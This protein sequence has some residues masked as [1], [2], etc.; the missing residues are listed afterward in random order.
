MA[1]LDPK[2]PRRRWS[3]LWATARG[4]VVGLL[5]A[6]SAHPGMLVVPN[7]SFEL[8]A[9][10][11]VNVDIAEWEEAPK[12]P[13][14]DEAAGFTWDQLTGVFKNTAPGAADHITNLHGNQA[15]WLFARPDVAIYQDYETIGGGASEPSRA[16]DVRFEEGRAYRLTV[17]VIGGGGNMSEGA[18]I[19]LRLYYRDPE[20]RRVPVAVAPVVHSLT[21]FPT[22]TRFVDF[23]VTAPPVRATD[24]WAGHHLGIEI[25]SAVG[26]ELEG[27]FWDLDHVRL[28]TLDP[29]VLANAR[30][31]S[32]QLRFTVQAAADTRCEVLVAPDPAAPET[33]WTV[34]G[35][36]DLPAGEAEWVEPLAA[37]GQRFYR[38][39][40]AF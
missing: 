10:P 2:P 14:F 3:Q 17:G 33:N 39:R 29:P 32:G 20:G 15:A 30:V 9:T 4:V 25:R 7:A 16:F 13:W 27:G 12:P 6:A 8:P 11:F 35:T 34:A 22:R 28:E 1:G 31:A 40:L 26:F 23:R 5:G 18:A 38:A 19:E 21:V 37:H 24:P 36:L